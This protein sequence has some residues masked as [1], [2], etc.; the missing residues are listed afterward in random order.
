MKL[1]ETDVSLSEATKCFKNK[2]NVQTATVLPLKMYH[3]VLK[4]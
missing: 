2:Q 4:V 3:A 1:T